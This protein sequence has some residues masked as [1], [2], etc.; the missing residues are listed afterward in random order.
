MTIEALIHGKDFISCNELYAVTGGYDAN[1]GA[2]DTAQATLEQMG[3]RYVIEQDAW[4][5]PNV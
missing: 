4:V 2:Y 3:W 1:G 5:K